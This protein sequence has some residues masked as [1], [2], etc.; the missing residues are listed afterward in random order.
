MGEVQCSR[1]TGGKRGPL[2]NDGLPGIP[3]ETLACWCYLLTFSYGIRLFSLREIKCENARYIRKGDP[4][5]TGI[6]PNYANESRIRFQGSTLLNICKMD[7][8]GL[9]NERIDQISIKYL[10]DFRMQNVQKYLLDILYLDISQIPV[11][12]GQEKERKKRKREAYL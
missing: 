7:T 9:C 8:R 12:S 4:H 2:S 11:H 1:L 6:T 10:T 5:E 3:T